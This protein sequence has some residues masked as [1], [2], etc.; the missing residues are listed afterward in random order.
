MLIPDL[1]E[2][3][4]L[5]ESLREILAVF[6]SSLKTLGLDTQQ[7]RGGASACARQRVQLLGGARG[8]RGFAFGTWPRAARAALRPRFPATCPGLRRAARGGFCR[9]RGVLMRSVLA[10]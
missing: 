5:S 4:V 9:N 7:V 6:R 3:M 2:E 10:A 8:P 1:Q